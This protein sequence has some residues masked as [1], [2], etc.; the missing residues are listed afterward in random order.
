ML[1]VRS[2]LLI[3]LT[4]ASTK[5]GK[6][7]WPPK[8]G[9]ESSITNHSWKVPEDL[10]SGPRSPIGQDYERLV[11]YNVGHYASLKEKGTPSPMRHLLTEDIERQHDW[12][13]ERQETESKRIEGLERLLFGSTNVDNLNDFS[14]TYEHEV[15]VPRVTTSITFEQSGPKITGRSL[16]NENENVVVSE[17]SSLPTNGFSTNTHSDSHSKNT[18][19]ALKT[20]LKKETKTAYPN[21]ATNFDQIN[22]PTEFMITSDRPDS[23]SI[24]FENSSIMDSSGHHDE[25]SYPPWR[26][27]KAI[28]FG[29]L[30]GFVSDLRMLYLAYL[31]H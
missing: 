16:R 28:Y 29:L 2:V 17:S 19:T 7:Q 20:I 6:F 25:S 24:Q 26:N 9:V 22:L 12:K 15:V 30:G 11:T 21:V 3:C 10:T 23:L 27:R 13:K 31:F 8:P 5:S 1:T 18:K 4:T 14:E